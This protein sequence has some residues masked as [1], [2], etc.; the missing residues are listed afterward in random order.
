[1]ALPIGNGG[2]PIE[3]GLDNISDDSIARCAIP[4]RRG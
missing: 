1:M 4:E 2:M 3:S